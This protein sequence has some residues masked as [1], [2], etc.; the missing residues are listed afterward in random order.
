MPDDVI[1]F[2]GLGDLVAFVASDLHKHE[3]EQ[4]LENLEHAY[5]SRL[6]REVLGDL[7]LIKRIV[8]LKQEAVVEA[9]IP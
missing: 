1:T 8:F 2:A 3:P 6:Q 7:L 5:N 9:V 4:L